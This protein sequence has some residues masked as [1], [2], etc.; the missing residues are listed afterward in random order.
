MKSAIL[1][2]TNFSA[3]VIECL[4]KISNVDYYDSVTNLEL[5]LEDKDIV[6]T[7]LNYYISDDTLKSSK[8]IKYLCSPTTG[9]NHININ[10][11]NIR[12]I[13][14]QGENEFLKEISATSEHIFGL[15]LSLLRNYKSIFNSNEHLEW[16][17]DQHIGHEINGNQIGII[18]M[19][20]IGKL[21]AKYFNTFGATINYY[22]INENLTFDEQNYNF[23]IKKKDSIEAVINSSNI[24]I[25]SVNYNSNNESL[26]NKKHFELLKDKFFINASRGEVINELDL[27]QFLEGNHFKGVALDVIS[28]ETYKNNGLNRFLMLAKNKNFIITPHIGGLTY[29]SL[30]LT[31]T[32]IFNK[33]IEVL[34]SDGHSKKIREL[35]IQMG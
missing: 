31:E 7:R 33:L 10:N 28:N 19:G 11:N 4:K 13:S 6:F 5:Y 12:V 24:V 29:R 8:K 32:F 17:R 9:L 30:K 25:L 26:I 2:P 22:D 18:G 34:I 3:Q 20:R 27:L 1:E 35:K 16:N 21:L 23:M 15:V 14:L